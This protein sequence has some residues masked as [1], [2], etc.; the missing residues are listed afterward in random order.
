MFWVA[1]DDCVAFVETHFHDIECVCAVCVCICTLV[2]T[3]C[4]GNLG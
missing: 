4:E 2:G 1:E 3:K